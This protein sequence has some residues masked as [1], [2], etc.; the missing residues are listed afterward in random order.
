MMIS[1]PRPSDLEVDAATAIS[2]GR[3][4]YQEDA[5]ITDFPIGGDIALAVVADGMGG[6]AAGDVASKIAVTEVFS[7][8]KLQ[9]GD[10]EA[11]EARAPQ[12]MREAAEAANGCIASHTRA[13][14]ETRGMGATLLAIAILRGRLFWISVGDSPLLLFRDGAL[15]QINEDHSL[16]PQIDYL[17]RAGQLTAEEGRYHPDRSCL[18]S[19][20]CG[21]KIPHVDCPDKPLILTDRDVVIAATDGIQSLAAD[22]IVAVLKSAGPSS[23]EIARALL[24]AVEARNDPDQDNVTVSV[25][26]VAQSQRHQPA[27]ALA[28][29]STPIFGT[30]RIAVKC[31]TAAQRLLFGGRLAHAGAGPGRKKT[32]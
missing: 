28:R 19:V 23:A 32:G 25:I 15:A 13:E 5:V 9:S 21:G 24:E 26:K 4:E 22:E 30:S 3:R 17:V 31:V 14:A 10:P 12:L 20:L 11:F 29:K 6:H 8:L 7:E 18:T 27:I 16:A 1:M 2:R